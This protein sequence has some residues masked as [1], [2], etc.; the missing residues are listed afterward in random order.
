M[1]AKRT[2]S[3]E[4]LAGRVFTPAHLVDFMLDVADYVP[5][6]RILGKHV[7]D[8]SCGDGAF[9]E[10]IVRRLAA[11]WRSVRGTGGASGL[12]RELETFVHGIELDP[13]THADCLARLGGVA[14]ELGLG[15]VRW[16]IRQGDALR[17]TAFDGCM[18]WVVGN[19]PYVR[20]HNLGASA[21][22]VKRQVFS[23]GG[24]TDLYLAFYELGFRMLSARGRL[25]YVTPS[26]WLNSLAGAHF[27]AFVRH[28]RNLV[29]LVDLGHYQ[30]FE[31]MAYVAIALFDAAGGHRT[32]R[33]GTYGESRAETFVADVP[34]EEACF[35]D[36]FRF[37]PVDK[38]RWLRA[39]FA[40]TA[41]PRVVAK[42]GFA[43]LADDV[44]I[45]DAFPFRRWVIPVVKAST[46]QWRKAFFPY[47]GR[48]KP[49][50]REAVFGDPDVAR[51]LV[52]RKAALLKGRDEAAAGD[53]HLF[54]RTQA[55]ADV[56]RDKWAVNAVVK[57]A[58]SVK[59]TRAPA[60]SGV[61]GGLYLLGGV[62]GERLRAALASD[63]FFEY[64]ALLQKYKSGGYYTFN[65]REL[66]RFL[67]WK[68][69]GSA[70]P[71]TLPGFD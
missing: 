64:V 29:R 3:R 24:M 28:R 58:A 54:G 5:D 59:L 62:P 31:A 33:F 17:E 15:A 12:V 14:R 45:A 36:A 67:N 66:G 18:D 4:K 63:D 47:D 65:T 41:P 51:W 19:P 25:C 6:G 20:V 61:Y 11:A 30:P 40:G 35:G 22:D 39:I 1:A 21:V 23:Q 26:S 71:G 48:G 49:V 43:T 70:A 8:N 52:E 46:G 60:G 69:A 55:L 27:R 9:L 2:A 53:W 13:G 7:I 68:L 42:N 10:A 44:F 56:A 32:V 57:D 38:L 37:A 50:P 34:L 16:D